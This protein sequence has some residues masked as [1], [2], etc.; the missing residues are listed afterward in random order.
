MNVNKV[1]VAGNLTR[2][3]ETRTI[4]SGQTVT[5]FGLATNR[6][7]TDKETGQK[8]KQTEYHNIVVWGKLGE[9][10]QEYL[11]KGSLAFVEGRLQTNVWE[12]QQGNKRSKTEIVAEKLQFGPKTS[13][14]SNQNDSSKEKQEDFDEKSS[15][16][17]INVEEIPF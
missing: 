4:S 1:I 14:S 7:W 13:G 5:S 6:F 8:Q 10:A 2:D 17:E 16:E 11:K 12:D 15:P 9:L 3:P